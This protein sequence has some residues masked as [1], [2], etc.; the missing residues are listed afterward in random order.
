MTCTYIVQP[1]LFNGQ[2]S[3]TA[4]AMMLITRRKVKDGSSLPKVSDSSRTNQVNAVF[5]CFI[6]RRSLHEMHISFEAKP[7]V[8]L[9]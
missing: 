2:F 5:A 9:D 8:M 3:V 7:A 1:H 4:A 6:D